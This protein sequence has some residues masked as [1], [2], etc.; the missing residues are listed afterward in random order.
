MLSIG[1][2]KLKTMCQ[3]LP[4]LD[5]HPALSVMSISLSSSRCQYMMQSSPSFFA[6]NRLEEIDECYR[7][8]LEAITNNRM[9][10][11]SWRQASIPLSPA[12]LGIRKL[13]DLAYPILEKLNLKVVD[14]RFASMIN[15][16]PADLTPSSLP[17]KQRSWDTLIVKTIYDEL[18]ASCGP[19]ERTRILASSTKT[20]SKWLQA[21]PSP[22]LGN[23]VT[24]ASHATKWFEIL[25]AILRSIR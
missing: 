11:T 9:A 19:T 25:L 1:L 13:V 8:K 18:L 22:Q 3:R 16:Y 20:S 10:V 15:D 12:D 5:V 23:L 6:M 14:E 17:Q 7:L 24:T 21:V 4:L 2:E